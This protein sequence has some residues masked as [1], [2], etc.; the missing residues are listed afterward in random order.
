M[1]DEGFGPPERVYV[2]NAWYDGPREGVADIGGVPHRFKSLFDDTE[3]EYFGSFLVWPI[4][5]VSLEREIE[6]W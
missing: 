4:D 3:E 1:D 6:Q 5:R 2:E